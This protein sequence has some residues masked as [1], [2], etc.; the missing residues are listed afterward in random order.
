MAVDLSLKSFHCVLQ[1][2]T[3]ELSIQTSIAY[4]YNDADQ[5]SI[6]A[7]VGNNHTMKRLTL[8]VDD[9]VVE[10]LLE[11]VEKLG[12]YSRGTDC[13]HYSMPCY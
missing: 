12:H 7:A 10:L 8:S 13:K 11:S 9:S 3:L 2:H 1:L 5:Q 6:V 4:Y